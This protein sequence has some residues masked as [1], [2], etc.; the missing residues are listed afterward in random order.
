M[1]NYVKNRIEIIGS[2]EQIKEVV[3]AFNNHNPAKLNRAHD[4]KIICREKRN[5]SLGGVG[6]FNDQTGVFTRRGEVD[7]LGLSDGWS[8]EINDSFDHFPDFEKVITPPENIF[9]GDLGKEEKEMCTREGRPNWLDFNIENWG[10]KWNSFSC[11]KEDDNIFTFETAWNGVPLIVSAMS[12]LFPDVTFKYEYSDE[13][14][15][16]NVGSSTFK[17]G[18]SDAKEIEGGSTEAYELAFKLR[19]DSKDDYQLINGSYQFKED[20]D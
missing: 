6:W 19:P 11:Q 7:V 12:S 8:F 18:L 10:S 2:K 4:N 16:Y 5:G 3:E 13:D 1:P 20:E 14:T 17:S 15:G 9:R